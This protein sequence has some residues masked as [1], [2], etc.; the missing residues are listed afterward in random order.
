MRVTVRKFLSGERYVFLLNEDGIPDFWVTHFVTQRLRMNQ[1]WSSIKNYLHDIKHLKLWESINERD[2]LEEIYNGKVPSRSDIND[3][4]EHCTFQ[5][6]VF[7]PKP[8]SKSNVVDMGEFYLSQSQDKPTVQKAQYINRVA[9]IIEF[10]YFIGLERVKHKPNAEKLFDELDKMNKLFKRGP[11]NT[12]LKK[13][14]SLETSGISDDVFEDFIAVAKPSSELNPFPD[15]AVK[16]RNYLI[17]Q[18]LYEAGLRCSEVLA[19]RISDIGTDI[20]SPELVVVRRHDNKDDPRLHEP[21]PKTEGRSIPI[22]KGLRDLLLYY[23]KE[24]RCQT[25]IAKTHPFIFVAHKSKRGCYTSGRPM[26]QGSVNKFFER[27]KA[28]K[29]EQFKY[30]TPHI[31]R[32]YFNDRLSMTIDE[33]RRANKEEIKRLE[34]EGR[35]EEAKQYA[36]QNTITEQRELEIRAELNG[37]SSLDS[38]RYY[39]KRTAKRKATEIRIKMHAALKHKVERFNNAK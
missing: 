15:Q 30:I 37:H 5:V 29:S 25:S 32:H 20:V 26:S 14:T 21:C 6:K 19:L 9:H 8:I 12:R 13:N 31:Y 7:K 23:I 10:L 38:G 33:E 22:S 16:F 1:S 36:Y 3:I 2:L 28:V 24:W 17:V 35:H 27:I 34:S 4:K 11:P 39:L 18:T